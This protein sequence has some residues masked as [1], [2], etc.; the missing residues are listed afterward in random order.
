MRQAML[1]NR[2][3]EAIQLAWIKVYHGEVVP[4]KCWQYESNA[5]WLVDRNPMTSS[6]QG[7]Y[8][9]LDR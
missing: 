4:Y 1:Q 8:Q 2:R 5:G 9:A 3:M 7:Q 6:P